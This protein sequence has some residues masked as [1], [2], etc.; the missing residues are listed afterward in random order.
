MYKFQKW[1]SPAGIS[2]NTS[3]FVIFIRNQY[4]A[5]QAPFGAEE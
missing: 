1:K 5:Q 4:G 2:E 3:G